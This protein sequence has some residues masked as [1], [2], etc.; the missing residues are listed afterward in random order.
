[1][2][3]AVT[4]SLKNIKNNEIPISYYKNYLICIIKLTAY[5]IKKNCSE[6]STV[7]QCLFFYSDN[8]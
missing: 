2:Y 3:D 7:L 8:I 6:K 4:D 1:M 5:V